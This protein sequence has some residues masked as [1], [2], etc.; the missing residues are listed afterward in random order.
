MRKESRLRLARRRLARRLSSGSRARPPRGR[1]AAPPHRAAGGKG[2][3]GSRLLPR[4]GSF[5]IPAKRPSR[6]AWPLEKVPL[7]LEA[8]KRLA[9]PA[10]GRRQFVERVHVEAAD[11]GC[12]V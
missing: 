12:G 8:A 1:V 2:T 5:R 3:L 9:P 6:A 11:C 10:L 7:R 4:A